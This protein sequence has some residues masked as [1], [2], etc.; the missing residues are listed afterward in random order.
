MVS[1]SVCV[2][3]YVQDLVVGMAVFPE[4]FVG[5][6]VVLN[7]YSLDLGIQDSISILTPWLSWRQSCMWVE[8]DCGICKN[9][10]VKSIHFFPNLREIWIKNWKHWAFFLSVIHR[11]HL[12]FSFSAVPKRQNC[13]RDI[14]FY[15]ELLTPTITKRLFYWTLFELLYCSLSHENFHFLAKTNNSHR[16]NRWH[17][18]PEDRG[19]VTQNIWKVDDWNTHLCTF[20]ACHPHW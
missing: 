3:L 17:H 6:E 9:Q 1:Y 8:I 19:H 18:I 10:T 14:C 20:P 16:N 2:W 7:L 12:C 5:L 15:W 13:S 4:L 11:L